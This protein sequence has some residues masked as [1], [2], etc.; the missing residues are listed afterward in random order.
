LM[1]VDFEGKF[2]TK[3][4]KP[5]ADAEFK[6]V[7]G[8]TG[9]ALRVITGKKESRPGIVIN[10]PDGGWDL[11]RYLYVEMDVRNSGKTGA[12]V[13]CRLNGRPWVTSR[14]YLEPGQGR[15]LKVLY[16]RSD[17]PEY[18]KK[19]FTGMRGLP[20][21]FIPAWSN[22]N[23]KV[24]SRLVISFPEPEGE[25]II[26]IDNI[27]ATG[28]FN[29]PSEREL[30]TSFFPFVDKFGQYKYRD[31]PGKIKSLKSLVENV[32][33]EEKELSAKPGP[34]DWDKYGGWK[35]GPELRATGNFYPVKYRGKWWMV[36]PDGRLFWS[37]G[38][39]GIRSYAKTAVT[40]REHYF[41]HLPAPGTPEAQF[42]SEETRNGKVL[43][44]FDFGALNLYWKYGPGWRDKFAEINHHR[45]RIW[46]VN[47]IANWSQ[48]EIY[49][50]RKT[51]YV[52]AISYECNNIKESPHKFPDVF[53]PGFKRALRERMAREKGKSAGD[54]WCIGYY[55]DNELTWGDGTS[56]ASLALQAGPGMHAKR[57]LINDLKAKYKSIRRLNK[58]WGTSFR[59]WQNMLESRKAPDKKRAYADLN[60]FDRK[61]CRIYFKTCR[62]VVKEVAPNNLYLGCRMDFHFY[63]DEQRH[64]DW[65]NQVIRTAG[66]YCD[67]ISF[68]RYRFTAKPL[69]P[70]RGTDRPVIIGEWQFGAIDRGNLHTG[71]CAV[72]DQK[73]RGESYIRFV[74]GALENPFMVGV[75]WYKFKD[76][77]VTG[78]LD[79][80]NYQNGFVDVCDTPYRE[81]VEACRKVGYSLYRYRYSAE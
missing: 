11:S 1:L 23:S 18:L 7:K 34:A 32:K 70:P 16:R 21:G 4:I 73:H 81:L 54:P 42:Y 62:D 65:I 8:E 53:D 50:M 59:S 48:P 36:D 67:V 63:P 69:V 37:H 3:S 78:R 66:K 31:W 71:P 61:V 45:L 47:T 9:T 2:D 75:H 5:T 44:L 60:K 64:L 26:D 15:T 30:E 24:I 27:K 39:D 28:S 13:S 51:P 38:I 10:A 43:K 19:Y 17:P 40:G 76:N 77:A 14:V 52:V 46:G 58:A 68:N 72:P 57:V 33:K 56:F 80:E 79:G 6:L 35:T 74:K 25:Q 20:G 49:L 55:V 22:I 41:E 12:W 29:P